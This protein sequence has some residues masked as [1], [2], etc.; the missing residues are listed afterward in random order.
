MLWAI[1]IVGILCLLGIGAVD[2]NTRH[3]KA[4]ILVL[5]RDAEALKAEI[6]E[7]RDRIGEVH[8]EAFEAKMSARGVNL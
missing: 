3:L 1:L 4:M 2:N 7:N 5:G 6:I 8:N